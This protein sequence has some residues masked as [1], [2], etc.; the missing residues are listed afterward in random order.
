LHYNPIRN[1]IVHSRN[2]IWRSK[3]ATAIRKYVEGK[4]SITT[5]N[6]RIQLSKEF[7]L[8]VLDNVKALLGELM[9]LARAKI[10]EFEVAKAGPRNTDG[11]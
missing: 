6:D 2:R 4:K 10:V 11:E 7:C 3:K 9:D 8:E 5:D 1:V